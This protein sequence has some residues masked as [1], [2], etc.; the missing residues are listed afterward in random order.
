MTDSFTL[1]FSCKAAAG[2]ERRTSGTG[3]LLLPSVGFELGV[4]ARFRF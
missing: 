1:G 4:T 3:E 2:L